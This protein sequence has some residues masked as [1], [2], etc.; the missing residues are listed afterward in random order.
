ML[1]KRQSISRFEAASKSRGRATQSAAT[2]YRL[3]AQQIL[4]PESTAAPGCKGR[5]ELI[6]A[7]KRAL[8]AKTADAINSRSACAALCGPGGVGKS[9]LAREYAWRERES[10]GGVWWVRAAKRE[11]LL[12]DLIALGVQLGIPAIEVAS[13]RAAAARLALDL[14]EARR[15]DKQW[16]VV[17]DNAESPAGIEGLTPSTNAHVL[18]TTRWSDWSGHAAELPVAVFPEDIAVDYLMA[19]PGGSVERPVEIRADVARL[20]ND[21]GCLPLALAV[22]RAHAWGMNW[23]F[24]Q[25]RRHLADMI[26]RQPTRTIDC[27]RSIAAIFELAISRTK[28]IA[29]EAERLLGIAAFLAPDLIPLDIVANDVMSELELGEAV[30][31]LADVSLI[32]RETLEDGSPGIS[33]HRLVQ[34]AMQLRLGEAA[35]EMMALATRLLA[36]VYPAGAI[37]PDDLRS[38]PACRRLGAHAVAVLGHAP[39]TDRAAEKTVHLLNQYALHLNARAEHA[40]AEPLMRRAF[41]ISEKSFGL[42][43]PMITTPLNYLAGL[44]RDTDRLGDAEPLMRRALAIDEKSFGPDHPM[45]ATDL[46]NLALVLEDTN[47]IREAEALYRRALA[48]DEKRSGPDHPKVAIRINNL[49]GLLQDSDRICEAEPLMRRALAISERSFGPDHPLVVAD[50]NNLSQLL[51]ASKRVG[52]AEALYRRALAIDEKSLG[53]DH[54]DVARDLNNLSLLLEAT[55]RVDE[56]EPL[57]RRALSIDE[58]SFGRDHPTVATDLNNLAGLLR[59]TDRLGEAEPLM[60]RALAI[61]EKSFGPDHPNVATDLNNLAELL[62]DTYHLG[63]AE[64]LMRR[65]LAILEASRGEGHPKTRT[66]YD[67]YTALLSDLSLAPAERA[68]KSAEPMST[69]KLPMAR[70]DFFSRVLERKKE[71][72]IVGGG[73]V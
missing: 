66:A 35:G 38:W 45:V 19:H 2:L 48:I 29:P 73:V 14:L 69:P 49:A 60:R 55:Q 51:E 59:D 22:A 47:R 34:E 3:A 68:I 15:R 71:R 9:V 44:L 31:A 62:R 10:Y 42:D 41:A 63:E 65:G 37:G 36:D 4:H 25:Y 13:N 54:P 21:V 17:Y 46:N 43:H 57:Y 33:V 30:A 58:R 39:E 26:A 12:D 52:E 28:A 11:T 20:A 1:S 6:Q 32:T 16:L 40:A 8:S 64:P 67:N 23:T 53:P 70:R 27:P 72:R 5:E 56:A 18:I 24:A 61:D 50:L 7:L